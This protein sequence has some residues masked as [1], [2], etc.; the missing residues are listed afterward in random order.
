MDKNEEKRTPQEPE[1]EPE[2]GPVVY[3]S[4]VKR[5]WAWVGVV[6][7][8][9]LVLLLTYVFAVGHAL[10]GTGPL[11]LCPALGGLGATAVLRYRAGEQRRG[12]RAACVL[13]VGL[14]A[15][16]LIWNLAMGIPMLI[17]NF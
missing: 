13:I 12:G 8:V 11:L 15:L 5:A 3:A 16:L 10:A 7:M 1:R 9:M 17:Q 6:Y 4:P 2:Q 14:C